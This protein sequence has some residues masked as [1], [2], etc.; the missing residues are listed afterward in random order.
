MKT[1]SWC[2]SFSSNHNITVIES[3]TF[4]QIRAK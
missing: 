2:K 1:V 3:E 4:I